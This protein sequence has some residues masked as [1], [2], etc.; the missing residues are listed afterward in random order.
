MIAAAGYGPRPKLT[1]PSSWPLI[2]ENAT[3]MMHNLLT[4]RGAL[5][6]DAKAWFHPTF[7]IVTP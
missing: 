7:N 4:P 5:V 3:Q 6:R 1:S 2:A